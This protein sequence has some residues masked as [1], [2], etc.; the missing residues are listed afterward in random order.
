MATTPT[1]PKWAWPCLGGGKLKL[2]KAKLQVAQ[3]AMGQPG[4]KIGELCR[5]IGVSKPTLNQHVPSRD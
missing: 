3:A 2:T 1:Q 5:E 4:A